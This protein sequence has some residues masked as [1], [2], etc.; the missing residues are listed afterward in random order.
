MANSIL[1]K[2]TVKDVCGEIKKPATTTWLVRVVGIARDYEIGTTNFG[3]FVRFKGQFRAI[4]IETGEVFDSGAMILP[5]IANNLIYGALSQDGSNAVEFAFDL[6]VK[7]S[8]SPT[9]Y[10]YIVSSLIESKEADP[11]AALLSNAPALP[12][13]PAP[14]AEKSKATPKAEG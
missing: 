6:G 5:D 7:P 11:L 10:D 2:I 14:S 8:K 4:K 13:L 1:K 3:Q 9:E 12:A